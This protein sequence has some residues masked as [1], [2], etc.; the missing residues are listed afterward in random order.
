MKKILL[1][2]FLVASVNVSA[3]PKNGTC[4]LDH[5]IFFCTGATELIAKQACKVG[6]G[7]EGTGCSS[8]P[9]GLVGCTCSSS[10][11]GNRLKANKKLKR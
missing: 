6:T 9:G 11:K 5:G 3:G 8:E 10:V 2:L 1:L 7:F 4:R